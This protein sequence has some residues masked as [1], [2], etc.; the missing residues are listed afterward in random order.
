MVRFVTLARKSYLVGIG[1]ICAQWIAS[2]PSRAWMVQFNGKGLAVANVGVALRTTQSEIALG[3][4][5]GGAT[6]S[7]IEGRR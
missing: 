5:V 3:P 7:R 2:G 6:T 1:S 4:F